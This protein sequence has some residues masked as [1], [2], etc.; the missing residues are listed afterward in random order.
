MAKFHGIIGFS[1]TVETSPGIWEDSIIEREYYG[2]ILQNNRRWQQAETLNDNFTVSNKISIVA[3]TFASRNLPFIKYVVWNG[4]RMKVTS[5]Q[6]DYPRI[7]I[8]L[9]GVYNGQKATA[10]I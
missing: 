7:T 9:G 5:A 2:D 1:Q 4:C 3:D 6:Y 8:D 10:S